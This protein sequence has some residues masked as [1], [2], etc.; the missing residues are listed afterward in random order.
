MFHGLI[1]EGLPCNMVCTVVNNQERARFLTRKFVCLISII[2]TLWFQN[3]SKKTIWGRKKARESCCIKPWCYSVDSTQRST[4]ATSN[5]KKKVLHGT[6][7]AKG[8][9]N[10]GGQKGNVVW[11]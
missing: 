3:M 8:I 6:V 9:K 2:I 7:N 10:I 5:N 4:F 1:Q 11:L